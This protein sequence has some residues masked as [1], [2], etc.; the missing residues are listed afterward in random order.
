[1]L[2]L[3]SPRLFNF[4]LPPLRRNH[5]LSSLRSLPTLLLSGAVEVA[6]A[7]DGGDADAVDGVAGVAGAVAVAAAA[8]DTVA[9]DA[10]DGVVMVAG[11]ERPSLSHFDQ[12]FR[13]L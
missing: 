12:I 9:A 5:R 11:G 10:A 8:E 7:A 3:L 1:M 13:L 2:L 6:A 4:L